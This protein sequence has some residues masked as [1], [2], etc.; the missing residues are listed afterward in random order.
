MRQSV[1]SILDKINSCSKIISSSLHGII[2]PQAYN[3][4]VV[5]VRFTDNIYGDGIKYS[6]YFDSV[7]IDAYQ[8]PSINK[9]NFTEKNILDLFSVY[10]KHSRIKKNLSSIQHTLLRNRPF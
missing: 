6:D 5:R 4:P 8:A 7:G 9:G 10:E 2:V 1:S 3:I